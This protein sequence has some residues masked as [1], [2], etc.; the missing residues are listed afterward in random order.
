ML[1]LL[2]VFLMDK[3]NLRQAVFVL[4]YPRLREG[5]FE[6][7][8]SRLGFQMFEERAATGPAGE[9]RVIADVTVEIGG[10]NS[11]GASDADGADIAALHEHVGI[12]AANVKQF[13]DIAR[14]EQA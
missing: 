12:G 4:C 8:G 14:I 2:D 3:V 6:M 9:A 5:G 10:T 13:G 11:H 1:P 7:Y